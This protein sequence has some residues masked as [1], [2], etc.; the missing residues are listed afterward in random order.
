MSDE[1]DAFFAQLKPRKTKTLFNLKWLLDEHPTLIQIVGNNEL[2][3]Q[4]SVLVYVL[5]KNSEYR[6][7]NLNAFERGLKHLGLRCVQTTHHVHV[8]K[9]RILHSPRLPRPEGGENAE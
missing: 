6:G 9:W 7:F 2:H 3:Y 1:R 5:R 8:K 4:R